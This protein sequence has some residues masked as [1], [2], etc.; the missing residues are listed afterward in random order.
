[1]IG[2]LLDF[3]Y[4]PT[5][6]HCGR[7]V[8]EQGAWCPSCLD[9]VLDIRF[10]QADQLE[11]LDGLWILG[12]YQGGLRS[13]I[14]DV[15]FN[16]KSSQAAC[17]GPLLS[18]FDPAHCLRHI[19]LVLPIPISQA[20]RQVRGYNQVDLFFKEWVQNRADYYNWQWFDI[21]IKETSQGDMW[22]MSQLERK[23]HVDKLFSIKKEYLPALEGK[24]LL[25]VD[26]IYTTG[27]TLVAA[28]HLLR[29]AGA[30][31]VYGLTLASGTR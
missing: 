28:A 17:I 20:K 25:L 13:L 26:D 19:N 15:K 16:G 2:W 4:P 7:P 24:E 5:C 22:H 27:A 3:L 18:A 1:M 12:R 21:L 6:P 23:R 9:K 31:T 11:G 10:L 14:H 30:K 8:K 29:Q